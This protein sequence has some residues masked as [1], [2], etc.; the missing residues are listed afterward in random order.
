MMGLMMALIPPRRILVEGLVLV[1]AE[2]VREER[3][4]NAAQ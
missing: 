3:G 1:L 2:D 4:Q